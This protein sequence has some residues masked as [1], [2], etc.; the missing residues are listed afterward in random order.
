[1]NPFIRLGLTHSKLKSQDG[2][3]RIGFLIGQD[4]EQL[5]FV[6]GEAGF[7]STS[8]FATA[9]FPRRRM[10]GR[11]PL[12]GFLGEGWNQRLKLGHRQG[13]HAEEPTRIR[14]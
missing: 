13:G 3:E 14:F 9:R 11:V 5:I 1:M 7:V 4:K 8:R 6:C 10:N 2:L 12:G